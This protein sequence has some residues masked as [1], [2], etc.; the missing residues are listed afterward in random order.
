[1]NR[2]N[3]HSLWTPKETSEFLGLSVATLAQQRWR[4]VGPPFL[5]LGRTVRYR[6]DAVETWLEQKTVDTRHESLTT[7]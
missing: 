4:G 6:P 5:R 3:A 2:R 7:T 1:M